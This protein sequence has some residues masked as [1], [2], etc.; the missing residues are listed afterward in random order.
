N[1][2]ES[3]CWRLCGSFPFSWAKRTTSSISFAIVARGDLAGLHVNVLLARFVTMT[4]MLFSVSYAGAWGQHKL[5]L[6][7]FLERAAALEYPAV[8]LGGKRPHLSPVDYPHAESVAQIKAVAD[9]LKI[10]IATIA[11][12]TDFTS[13]HQAKEVP[14]VE[15]Q[16]LYI[17]QL[18]ELGR[19]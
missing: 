10:E 17:R 19:A 7:P 8:E 9:R 16:V 2:G 1:S 14:F 3:S 12:Y 5:E 4:P 15:M 13:G 11:G 6:I 18:A